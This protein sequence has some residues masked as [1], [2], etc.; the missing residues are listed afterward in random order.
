M[1]SGMVLL[2]DVGRFM[3]CHP[4]LCRRQEKMTRTLCVGC[5]YPLKPLNIC[6]ILPSQPI[7]MTLPADNLEIPWCA[8]VNQRLVKDRNEVF[9]HALYC[10]CTKQ[11]NYF[12][13]GKPKLLSAAVEG[14]WKGS[15]LGPV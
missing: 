7:F 15:M 5:N 3:R 12:S 1:A 11:P 6:E 13:C 14:P 4:E 2:V 10:P 9:K 8:S